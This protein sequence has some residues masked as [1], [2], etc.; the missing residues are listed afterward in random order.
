MNKVR[1]ILLFLTAVL[2]V[3]SAVAQEKSPFE[4]RRLSFNMP[5]Y[6]EISPVI[7]DDG[8]LFCSDRR[9]SGVTDRTSFDNRRLYSIY[10]AEKKTLPTG[11]NR[12]P[13]KATG[14]PGSIPGPCV[15]LLT[16]RQCISQAKLK[17]ECNQ[18]TGSSGIT[19][20]FSGHSFQVPCLIP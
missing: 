12:L 2:T 4:I 10:V 6:S 18:E 15:L 16:G 17:P 3:N 11:E 5:G 8:I 9:L 19:A 1:Y 20:G 7:T 14:P 13:L